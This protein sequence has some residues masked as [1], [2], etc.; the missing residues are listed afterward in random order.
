MI[1]KLLWLGGSF[2]VGGIVGIY[3][4]EHE[5]LT[6]DDIQRSVQSAYTNSKKLVISVTR[7]NPST[8][9]SDE[10]AEEQSPNLSN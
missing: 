6:V 8:P 1:G 10:G 4:R 5:M 9:L 7:P 2:L 3:V